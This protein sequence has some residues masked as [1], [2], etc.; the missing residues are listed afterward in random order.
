MMM[1]VMKDLKPD[2][3]DEIFGLVGEVKAKFLRGIY[4]GPLRGLATANELFE[5]FARITE[6]PVPGTT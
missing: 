5:L 2:Q 4:E 6:P 3:T 1:R